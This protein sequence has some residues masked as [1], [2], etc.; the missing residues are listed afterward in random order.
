MYL[1]RLEEAYGA[2]MRRM[3]KLSIPVFEGQAG[4]FIWADFRSALDPLFNT[5][6]TEGS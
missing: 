5:C 6:S 1:F 3:T 2:V 4:L